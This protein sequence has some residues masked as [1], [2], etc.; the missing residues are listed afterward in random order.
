MLAVVVER[1]GKQHRGKADKWD[2]HKSRVH[3][4]L[5]GHR[6]AG[7]EFKKKRTSFLLLAIIAAAASRRQRQD[8]VLK[9]GQTRIKRLLESKN[10]HIFGK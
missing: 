8:A 7:R 4:R 5:A 3:T 2:R 6:G 1:A 10:L 9:E